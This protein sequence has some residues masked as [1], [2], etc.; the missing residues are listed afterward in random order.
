[1]VGEIPEDSSVIVDVTHSYRSLPLICL[2]A[3]AYLKSARNVHLDGLVYGAFE[4][5]DEESK[6]APVFDLMPMVSLLD[7]LS[8]LQSLKG[9]LDPGG[10]AALLSRVQDEA[11]RDRRENAPRHLA[12][13]GK[14]MKRFASALN[15]GRV[16]ETFETIP[17]LTN[18]AHDENLL[19]EAR[20][21]AKP[22]QQVLPLISGMVNSV[23]PAN[24]DEVTTHL[25][26]ARLYFNKGLYMQAIS[27]LREWIVTECMVGE[28]GKANIYDRNERG[29]IEDWLNEA[30]QRLSKGSKDKDCEMVKLWAKVRDTRNDVDHLGFRAQA[31][32][33]RKIV[34]KIEQYIQE[35]ERLED[36][37]DC[38]CQ[39]SYHEERQLEKERRHK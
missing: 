32:S 22:L 15:L 31:L 24:A 39:I 34:A 21:W 37:E 30:T 7:W 16:K 4:A 33:S 8:G 10:L 29:R 28:N 12:V 38:G 5:M 19:E 36:E 2:L 18:A 11:H 3:I 6:T 1:M 26:L 17:N 23:N 20:T 35:A 27:L 14:E 9:Q 13:F 25:R